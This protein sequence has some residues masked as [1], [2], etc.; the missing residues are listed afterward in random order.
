MMFKI[1]NKFTRNIIMNHHLS[2][3]LADS[4][5]AYPF[6]GSIHRITIIN[7]S[8][9]YGIINILLMIANIHIKKSLFLIKTELS[10]GMNVKHVEV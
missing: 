10:G 1:A 4:Q 2:P 8:C 3:C 9:S 7:M 6:Q 5:R